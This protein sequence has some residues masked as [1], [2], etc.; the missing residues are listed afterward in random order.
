MCCSRN[1]TTLHVIE[2]G[3]QTDVVW[4]DNVECTGQEDNIGHCKHSGW[5][6]TDCTHLNF[7]AVDCIGNTNPG[8][9]K[10]VGFS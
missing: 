7:A 2:G 1:A 10:V 3:E 9:Y 6:Q 4:M 8:M 5:A